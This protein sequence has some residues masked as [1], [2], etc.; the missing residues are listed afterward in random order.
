[1]LRYSVHARIEQRIIDTSQAGLWTMAKLEPCFLA[2]S[3][4]HG[5]ARPRAAHRWKPLKELFRL[6]PFSNCLQLFAPQLFSK[7]HEIFE[8]FRNFKM[9]HCKNGDSLANSDRSMRMCCCRAFQ[10]CL[11]CMLAQLC[12]KVKNF[13]P[14]LLLSRKGVNDPLFNL[15]SCACCV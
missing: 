15:I 3:L 1:M 14:I 13:P 8:N 6:E 10:R 4:G 11:T 7:N 12:S 9:I 5:K 2:I